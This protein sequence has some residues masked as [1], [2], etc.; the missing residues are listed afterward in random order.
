VRVTQST[1]LATFSVLAFV[2]GCGSERSGTPITPEPKSRIGNA[3]AIAQ[4]G[5]ILAPDA[6]SEIRALPKSEQ[7]KRAYAAVFPKGGTS[8]VDQEDTT[9]SYEGGDVIWASFGLVLIAPATNKNAYPASSGALGIFYLTELNGKFV[10]RKSWPATI[11][12]SIMGEPPERET[13]AKFGDMPVVISKAAGFWQGIACHHTS[14][15]GLYPDVGP[16]PLASFH[17]FYDNGGAE[18]NPTK[19]QAIEGTIENVIA[20]QSFDVRF[21]GTMRFVAHYRKNGDRYARTDNGADI[22]TC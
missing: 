2:A 19:I 4:T 22:P 10:V 7:L 9:F 20:G 17:S 6:K 12:G 5:K 18:Q 16:R 1:S 11:G 8:Y 21:D 13:S 14:V 3:I 15:V